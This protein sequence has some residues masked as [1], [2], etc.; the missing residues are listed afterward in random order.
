MK[1][2]ES[3]LKCSSAGGLK[4]PVFPSAV[5]QK[6]IDSAAPTTTPVHPVVQKAAGIAALATGC[7][8]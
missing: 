8:E 6:G 2:I 1:S 5:Y 3:V 4:K 7:A